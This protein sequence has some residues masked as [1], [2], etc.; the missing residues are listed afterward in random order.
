[1]A[2]MAQLA[3]GVHTRCRLHR[4]LRGA[5]DAEKPLATCQTDSYMCVYVLL[6]P[7]HNP[8]GNPLETTPG[9]VPQCSSTKMQSI[10][11]AHILEAT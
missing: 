11:A 9:Q 6:G 2:L 3:C 4:S 10:D 8:P 5:A 1:M 7:W